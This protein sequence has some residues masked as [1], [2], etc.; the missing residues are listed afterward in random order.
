MACL[1]RTLNVVAWTAIAVSCGGHGPAV[2]P[3]PMPDPPAVICP[4]DI[5][6]ASHNGV[7]PNVAFD[8]PVGQGGAPPIAVECLPASG[9]EFPIGATIVSCHAADSLSRRASCTFAVNVTPAP[10]LEK[11]KFL[12]FG[13]SLTEGKL[14]RQGF[15]PSPVDLPDG[16]RAKLEAKL[17]ERYVD[18]KITIFPA[19]WGGE[20]VAEG[21]HRLPEQEDFYKPEVLLLLEGVNDVTFSTDNATIT[22]VKEALRS[23][24]REAKGR[25]EQVFIATLLPLNPSRRSVDAAGAVLA[26]NAQIKTMAEE[27]NVTLVDLYAAVPL[28]LIGSDGLHPTPEGYTAMADAWF[29]AIVATLEIPK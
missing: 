16:Y 9:S 24:V 11:T 2:Q 27:E 15:I 28:S 21:K 20:T 14:S 10:R 13:D 6:L 12:A 4:A 17:A 23:M 29:K 19:G 18:Q 26:L 7:L 3:T 5:A 25:G 8:T 22:N 1:T